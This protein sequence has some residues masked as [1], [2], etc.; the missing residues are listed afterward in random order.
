MNDD[1]RGDAAE[2]GEWAALAEVYEAA[3]SSVPA[4]AGLPLL[5]TLAHAYE[6]ELAN[7]PLA[8]E[9]NQQVLALEP[10]DQQAV[11][12]LERLY[13]ATGQH[14]E[15]LAIYDKKLS[16]AGSDAE[17]RD[18]RLQL[19]LLYEEQVRDVE[20]ALALYRDIL[21]TDPDDLQALRALG[22]LYQ[23]TENW[24]ELAKVIERQLVLCAN[25]A[26]ACADLKFSLG[27]VSQ[28]HLE[29]RKAGA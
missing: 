3:L 20:K 17:K 14:E 5:A 2:T 4:S 21:K 7:Y 15:L 6:K 28:K 8:I 13:V 18:V 23:G 24:Q 29:E 1:L 19:A 16:L 9:R 25:D 22:R 12:G 26:L 11:L 27:E 10:S